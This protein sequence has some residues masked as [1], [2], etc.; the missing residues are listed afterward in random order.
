M[1]NILT[2]LS[3]TVIGGLLAALMAGPHIH[4]AKMQMLNKGYW[5]GKSECKEGV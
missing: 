2:G 1:R 4:A 3:Y 5:M